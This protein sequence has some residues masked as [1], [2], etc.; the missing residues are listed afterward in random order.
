VRP[1][2]VKTPRRLQGRASRRLA[3]GSSTSSRDRRN[4]R[5]V[6]LLLDAGYRLRE[7]QAGALGRQD[8]EAF[9]RAQKKQSDVLRR[10][11]GE[12]EQLLK[13]KRSG[14]SASV[15]NEVEEA[16]RATAI[17]ETGREALARGLFVEPPRAEGFDVVSQFA[18]VAPIEASARRKDARENERREATAA[19]KEA[20]IRLRD[21]ERTAVR[22]EREA[23]EAGREA[24]R[25]RGEAN[26]ARDQADAANRDV[27]EAERNLKGATRN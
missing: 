21:A 27:E 22:A 11:R 8:R 5:E 12:A 16:L 23:E 19:L 20:R 25:L 1:A 14:A 9:E 2:S 26:I 15:L 4:R 17:S 10:L 6:D 24:E 13:E 3:G 18:G 7:A